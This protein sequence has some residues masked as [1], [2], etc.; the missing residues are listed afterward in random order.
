MARY[1][2]DLES[3]FDR[4]SVYPRAETL[5]MAARA[6]IVY[7]DIYYIEEEFFFGINQ[8][9]GL[10][11]EFKRNSAGFDAVVCDSQTIKVPDVICDKITIFG[12]S[13]WG[14]CDGE[15]ILKFTDGS[16]EK[17]TAAYLDMRWNG[18]ATYDC[19]KNLYSEH[20]RVF[21]RISDR[22]IYY[23]TTILRNKESGLSKII[24]PDH[25]FM[26]IMAITLEKD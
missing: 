2:V 1:Y 16:E 25:M 26:N 24:F 8:E 14:Y 7:D 21:K 18:N 13:E 9:K 6:K 10:V 5:E 20:N 23:T 4:Q 12:F 17:A 15:F 22:S 19:D 11:A 3:I